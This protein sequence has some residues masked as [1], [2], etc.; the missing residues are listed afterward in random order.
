M[1]AAEQEEDELPQL[2]AINEEEARK[3]PR[4]RARRKAPPRTKSADEG[5]SRSARRRSTDGTKSAVHRTRSQEGSP[6]RPSRETVKK[7]HQSFSG[8]DSFEDPPFRRQG[9]RDSVPIRPRPRD[10][11]QAAVP[12]RSRSHERAFRGSGKRRPQRKRS[13][14]GGG[15]SDEGPEIVITKRGAELPENATEEQLREIL[16]YH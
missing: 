14:G 3:K 1:E 7:M 15:A 12:R 2:D 9:S 4:V 16:D 5:M 10:A 11:G 8:S 13:N 6:V